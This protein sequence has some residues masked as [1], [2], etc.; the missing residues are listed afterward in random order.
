MNTLK[1]PELLADAAKTRILVDA[2]SGQEIADELTKIY[3]IPYAVAERVKEAVK[4]R[5]ETRWTTGRQF[6][7]RADGFPARGAMMRPFMCSRG[8]LMRNRPSETCGGEHLKPLTHGGV[9]APPT[10][11]V[12][13]ASNQSMRQIRLVSSAAKRS[14]EDCL[15]LK[16]WTPTLDRAAKLPVMVWLHGGGFVT[17]SGALKLYSGAAFARRGVVLVTL[18]YRLGPLGFMPW[19]DTSE[20]AAHDFRANWG[21]LDQIAALKWIRPNIAGFG[22]QSGLRH[23]FWPV[24]RIIERQLPNDVSFGAGTVSSCNRAEWRISR[25]AGASRRRLRAGCRGSRAARSE[26]LRSDGL[27]NGL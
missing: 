7:P 18:N 3:A 8:Y 5:E 15:Y 25:T 9:N 21:L 2:V 14:S 16:I 26:C 24:R 22:R 6:G 1:D 12:R 10:V 20:G 23:H 4:K 13:A 19:A 27:S 17:G 11:L